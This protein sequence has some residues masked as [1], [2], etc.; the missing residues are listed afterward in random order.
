MSGRH[1]KRLSRM[2]SERPY[3]W[4]SAYEIAAPFGG[5]I[6]RGFVPEGASLSVPR[7][8]FGPVAR[9]EVGIPF[10]AGGR[11]DLQVLMQA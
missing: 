7:L 3:G 10:L 6:I 2:T 11:S 8:C 5:L 4:C 9:S 1:V